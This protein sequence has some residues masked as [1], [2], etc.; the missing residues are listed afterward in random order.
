MI[1]IEIEK[2]KLNIPPQAILKCER[3]GDEA[4]YGCGQTAEQLHPLCTKH[5]DKFIKQNEA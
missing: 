4:E 1:I 5:K 3:C 2:L